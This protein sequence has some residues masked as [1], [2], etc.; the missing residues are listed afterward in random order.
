MECI[1]IITGRNR[2]IIEGIS[3]LTLFD[4]PVPLTL[5]LDKS[6]MTNEEDITSAVLGSSEAVNEERNRNFMHLATIFPN[7]PQDD[8]KEIFDK[9]CGDLNWTIDLLLESKLEQLTPLASSIDTEDSLFQELSF[10]VIGVSNPEASAPSVQAEDEV[11]PCI[12]RTTRQWGRESGRK[13]PLSE[14]SQQLKRHLEEN[15]TF[16]DASYSEHTLRIRKLWHG[17]PLDMGEVTTKPEQSSSN[18]TLFVEESCLGA[19]GSSGTRTPTPH[20]RDALDV[21]RS[22]V[23]VDDVDSS[24]SGTEEEDTLPITLDPVFVSLLYQKFGDPFVPC[25]E[26]LWPF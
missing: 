26:G 23:A 17:E 19:I 24:S 13:A 11:P 12:V 14:E 22:D 10:P 7:A 4:R 1:R 5:T 3:P 16:S 6:S 9:C 21:H 25:S 18:N 15:V 2:S 8:L 20:A